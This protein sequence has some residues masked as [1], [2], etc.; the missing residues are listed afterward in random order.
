MYEK[1]E[2]LRFSFVE[3]QSITQAKELLAP[4]IADSKETAT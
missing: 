2:G 4:I 1:N 3:V